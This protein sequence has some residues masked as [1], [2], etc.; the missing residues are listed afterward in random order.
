MAFDPHNVA[1]Q[2]WSEIAILLERVF[3]HWINDQG[4]SQG[5]FTLA[6]TI[7]DT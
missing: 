5:T 4:F 7:K 3:T 2:H 6:L 1:R